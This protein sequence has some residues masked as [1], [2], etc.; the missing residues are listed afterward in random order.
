M[1]KTLLAI[2]LVTAVIFIVPVLVYGAFSAVG[3]AQLQGDAPL[4]FLIGVLVSKIGTAAAFVLF[5]RLTPTELGQRWV[6]YA[7]IWWVMYAFG[8]I[9]QAIG[10]NYGAG[11]AAAGILSEALYFPLSAYLLSRMFS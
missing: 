7:A 2:G 1:A 5:F 8:E 6:L 9:G 3:L 10:P 4:A 11:E